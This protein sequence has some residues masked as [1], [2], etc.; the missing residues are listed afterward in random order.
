MKNSM[1]KP[2]CVKCS[3]SSCCGNELKAKIDSVDGLPPRVLFNNRHCQKINI[4]SKVEVPDGYRLCLS[5]KENLAL[6]GMV[7]LNSP[8]N[9]TNGPVYVVLL[10]AG[11][12]IVEVKDGDFVADC[13]LEKIVNCVWECE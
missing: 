4:D 10:N 2:I 12:E 6:K 11:R 9:F 8:G 7:L 5:I 1:S 3:G 13:W